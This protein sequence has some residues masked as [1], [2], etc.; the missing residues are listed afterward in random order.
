MTMIDQFGYVIHRKII[1]VQNSDRKE[2]EKYPFK[3]IVYTMLLILFYVS[4]Y[5]IKYHWFLVLITI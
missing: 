1:V 5:I 2:G 3:S 4:S